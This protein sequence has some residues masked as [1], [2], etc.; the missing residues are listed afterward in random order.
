MNK[1]VTNTIT[2]IVL[3]REEKVKTTRGRPKESEAAK[4]IKSCGVASIEAEE[5]IVY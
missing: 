5:A 2:L 1:Y 3:H 4:F